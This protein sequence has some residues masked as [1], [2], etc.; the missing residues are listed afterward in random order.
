MGWWKYTRSCHGW[1]EADAYN[2]EIGATKRMIPREVTD[3]FISGPSPGVTLTHTEFP[4]MRTRRT[5][6]IGYAASRREQ[7]EPPLGFVCAV[8]ASKAAGCNPLPISVNMSERDR[9]LE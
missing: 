5:Q 3:Y 6:K 8:L 2:K 1:K 7:P 9:Q 4:R